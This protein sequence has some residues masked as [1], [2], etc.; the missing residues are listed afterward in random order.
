M[1]ANEGSIRPVRGWLTWLRRNP[2]AGVAA[3]LTLL[4]VLALALS[5]YP[6]IDGD[7]HY[8]WMWARSLVFDHDL[9]LSND[10]LLC[11]DPWHRG[12]GPS[13]HALNQWPLGPAL[14]WAPILQVARWLLP[15]GGGP[16]GVGCR[17][18]WAELAM[19]GSAL[20]A[21]GA[22]WLAL[23]LARRHA[24]PR[25]AIALGLAAVGLCSMLPFYAIVAPS[26]AHA[27]AALAVALFVERWDRFREAPTP[28]RGVALG[29]VLGLAMLMRTQNAL[30]AL[31]PLCDALAGGRAALRR[32][33]APAAL[34]V[35]AAVVVESPYRWAL[36]HMYGSVFAVPQ[37]SWY[38]R[39]A[40]SNPV[41]LL[42]SSYNGLLTTTPL[43]Y[44]AVLV[45]LLL[46]FW[47]AHRRLW[48][49]TV[50]FLAALYVN[51]AVWDWWGEASFSARRLADLA[52][53]FALASALAVAALFRFAE[54]APRRAAAAGLL[55]AIALGALWNQGAM[56]SEATGR[57]RML[58]A[59]AAPELW[60]PTAD[61]T[62]RALWHRVGNPLAWPASLPFALWHRVHPRAFDLLVGEGFFRREYHG[63]TLE[64]G[65]DVFPFDGPDAYFPEGFSPA[66]QGGRVLRGS[67]R[68]LLPLFEDDLGAIEVE[69]VAPVASSLRLRWNGT[70]LP[71]LAF[72]QGSSTTACPLP[73]GT[74]RVGVNEVVF[75][76][77][78]PIQLRS[79]RFL[80]RR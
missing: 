35:V 15:G 29:A 45:L 65:T 78:G 50:L 49:L 26:Y 20:A 56:T 53:P 74:A 40:H 66:R 69:A 41:G 58:G 48:P 36:H 10:A 44:P 55:G 59:R 8:T 43:L 33:L 76:A 51:G 5:P 11:G 73:A 22:L 67:G 80:P 52:G 21:A 71:V 39:W 13:G 28:L 70:P 46:P 4:Y 79:L 27:C 77:A 2:D 37:G 3:A 38:L 63:L 25:G 18:S 47:P 16:G 64:P 1:G 60:T 9:D 32:W 75:Q 12:L 19:Q 31:L 61:R 6:A 57:T 72:S 17:G 14:V 23:A 24:V 42:F 30:L 54:R 7:G 68:V 62:G 34:F